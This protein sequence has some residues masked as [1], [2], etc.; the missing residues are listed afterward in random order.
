MNN[1]IR[2][3]QWNARSI[4]NKKDELFHFLLK[5]DIDICLLCET[6]LN[7]K[8]SIKHQ[9]FFCYRLDRQHGGGGGVAILIKKSINHELLN[10]QNTKV[11]KNIGVRV[12]S[13]NEFLDIYS[14]YYPGGSSRRDTTRK[15][16]FISDLRKLTGTNNN[17]ERYKET[18]KTAV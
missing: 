1:N 16:N 17:Y 11:I 18:Q 15:Q 5:T 3:L 8:D 2:L 10:P 9:N 7:N 4:R 14:C 13:S 6:W 12:K